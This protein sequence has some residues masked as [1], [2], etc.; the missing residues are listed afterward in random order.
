MEKG[1][2]RQPRT[3]RWLRVRHGGNIRGRH[4]QQP[5]S[6]TQPQ[7]F[8]QYAEDACVCVC[9]FTELAGAY[10]AMDYKHLNVS[11]DIKAL[12]QYIGRYD[13]HTHKHKHRHTRQLTHTQLCP[14]CASVL[15][16]GAPHRY[17]PQQIDLETKLKPF[18]PDYIPSV[19]GLDE[20]IK[21]P[22]P[23]GKPDFLGLKVCRRTYAQKHNCGLVV[24][25][26]VHTRTHT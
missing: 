11:D 13:T 15:K 21:V 23:D 16:R 18:I 26:H 19:G 22:R 4:T 7:G 20:F 6:N 3:L 24:C 9:V 10:N 5:E 12:F 8:R 2:T 25:R 1:Y 14:D 17:K